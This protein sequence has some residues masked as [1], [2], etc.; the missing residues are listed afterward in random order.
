MASGPIEAGLAL[1][2][3]TFRAELDSY[4]V[5]AYQRALKGLSADVV[6]PACDRLIDEA[7]AGR[8]F[9]PMPTA[10]QWKEACSKVI[11]A[12]RKEAFRLG[13][14]GCEHPSFLEEYQD[15]KGVWWTR[16]CAC[17]QRGKQL[18]EAAGQPLALPSW[19]EPEN[20]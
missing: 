11:E 15:D 8:K 10:P 1:L 13:T 18:M 14:V 20:S 2:M 6:L 5:R 9:F 3:S 19:T 7:A 12:Q 16:R 17:Y 4:Q